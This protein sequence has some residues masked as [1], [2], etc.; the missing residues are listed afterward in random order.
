MLRNDLEKK[1]EEQIKLENAPFAV[2]A[3]LGKNK[4]KE[5]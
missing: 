4:V 5:R 1:I 2:V 3:T